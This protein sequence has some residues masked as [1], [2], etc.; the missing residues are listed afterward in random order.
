MMRFE[1]LAFL[2]HPIIVRVLALKK[3]VCPDTFPGRH[4]TTSCIPASR[5]NTP[6]PY[7]L[8]LLS[9]S[10]RQRPCHRLHLL[11]YPT[12]PSGLPVQPELCVKNND[13][14]MRHLARSGL[15]PSTIPGL[16]CDDRY[17]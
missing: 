15:N 4:Q 10:F 2:H 16:G 12:S 1:L 14:P 13:S 7:T 9:R 5:N 3:F 8:I 17:K 6:A 11:P